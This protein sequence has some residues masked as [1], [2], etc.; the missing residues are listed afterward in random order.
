MPGRGGY[1]ELFSLLPGD[2]EG[3]AVPLRV[4]RHAEAAMLKMENL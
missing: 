3:G 2:R 4:L 1:T